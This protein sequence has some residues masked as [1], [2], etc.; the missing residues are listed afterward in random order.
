MIW[1]LYCALLMIGL[2]FSKDLHL[3]GLGDYQAFLFSISAIHFSFFLMLFLGSKHSL[4]L[5]P[6]KW[7]TFF[8][9][10]RL[11][12]E[13][14]IYGMVNLGLLS[15]DLTFLG[16][17]GDMVFALLAPVIAMYFYSNHS[18]GKFYPFA[19]HILGIF[20]LVWLLYLGLY[21]IGSM[22]KE[23]FLLANPTW[24]KYPW[25]WHWG[26]F[27]P[28]FILAHSISIFRLIKKPAH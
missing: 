28:V 6:D 17:N 23:G 5:L 4:D 27:I 8:Q 18:V 13:F 22:E 24:F 16:Y 21:P 15:S 25:L 7:L 11:P 12:L 3:S 20:S 10:L 1:L 9:V 2:A 19:F 26:F 14:C